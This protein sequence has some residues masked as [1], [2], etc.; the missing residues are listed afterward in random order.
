MSQ[1][2]QRVAGTTLAPT[3]GCGA[4]GRAD[5][6]SHPIIMVWRWTTMRSSA[7][8]TTWRRTY[9]EQNAPATAEANS[10]ASSRGRSL[11]STMRS[12]S[13]GRAARIPYR[14]WTSEVVPI[15]A[16]PSYRENVASFRFTAID[17]ET[18]NHH[19]GSPCAVGLARVRGDKIVE[20]VSWLMQPPPQYGGFEPCNVRVH[21]INARTIAKAR[22]FRSVLPDILSFIGS[23]V[24]C[25][26]RPV[27]Q[28]RAGRC[29]RRFGPRELWTNRVEVADALPFLDLRT[30]I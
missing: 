23:D 20:A 24:V 28:R 25:A 3:A 6:M 21:G 30:E 10:S 15:A 7:T 9:A 5:R 14:R 26:Q 27:R 19:R 8:W 2:V 12:V 22:A 11:R 16:G 1:N 17:F 18:A 13:C 29:R 4:R